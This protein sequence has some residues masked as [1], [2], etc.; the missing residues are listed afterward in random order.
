MRELKLTRD[1]KF[2]WMPLRVTPKQL[3][4]SIKLSF[5]YAI[6]NGTDGPTLAK[7]AGLRLTINTMALASPDGKLI[8]V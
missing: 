5:S 8:R 6:D 7:E 3:C 2:P 1:R 4:W